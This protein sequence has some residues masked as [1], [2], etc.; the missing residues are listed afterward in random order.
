MP[1]VFIFLHECTVLKKC[2]IHIY[3]WHKFESQSAGACVSVLECHC[4]SVSGTPIRPPLV[5]P[6]LRSSWE[7]N[8]SRF[9]RGQ[10]LYASLPP[11]AVTQC[12]Q[13][14][15][16]P[17][18]NTTHTYSLSQIK[19]I[20]ATYMHIHSISLHIRLS[21]WQVNY[22]EW[23]KRWV[24]SRW[25]W[26]CVCEL[27]RE[28]K[29][30]KKREVN[31]G[32]LARSS[33]ICRCVHTKEIRRAAL[34]CIHTWTHAHYE[35]CSSFLFNSAASV[36]FVSHCPE[37]VWEE[38]V[39]MVIENWEIMPSPI[40]YLLWTEFAYTPVP[41]CRCLGFFLLMF[42]CGV[43]LNVSNGCTTNWV[44]CRRSSVNQHYGLFLAFLVVLG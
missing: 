29:R 18:S 36:S 41:L 38:G 11:T 12:I 6:S 34:T 32:N 17:P 8:L 22:K 35:P 9:L 14:H 20:S 16:L 31:P 43:F 19:R 27:V 33:L 3:S 24:N 21:S 39:S 7:I 13:N 15:F 25:W 44:S 2:L 30:D 5:K 26:V 40:S 4:V 37:E 10:P 42:F 28:W 1:C 23:Q